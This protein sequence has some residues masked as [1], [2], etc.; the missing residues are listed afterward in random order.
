MYFFYY[1]G[2]VGQV[3]LDTPHLIER[4]NTI[5]DLVEAST[6]L[7]NDN[8]EVIF[9]ENLKFNSNDLSLLVSFKEYLRGLNIDSKIEI[10][11]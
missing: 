8:Y 10:A 9:K 4:S 2:F 11:D 3:T 1:D 7:K 5:N 6:W